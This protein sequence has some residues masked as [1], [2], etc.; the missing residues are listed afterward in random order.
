VPIADVVVD[1]YV[2]RGIVRGEDKSGSGIL[3]AGVRG[4]LA[5][6]A[7]PFYGRQ[8]DSNS[9]AVAHDVRVDYGGP[10]M[11]GHPIAMAS[12]YDVSS[13][14]QTVDNTQNDT[15][16]TRANHVPRADGMACDIRPD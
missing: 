7:V 9:I 16:A 4:E 14:R 6:V 2:E 5:R 11:Q 13:C 12:L 10:G 8:A 15:R 1:Q 3:V